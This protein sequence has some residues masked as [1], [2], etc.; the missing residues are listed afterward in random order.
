MPVKKTNAVNLSLF[1]LL[2][3]LEISFSHAVSLNVALIGLAS[4]FLIWRRAFKSLVVL[5]LLP[6]IPAAST[7]WPIRMRITKRKSRF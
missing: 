6:L 7:Y 2:L 1:I 3:T 4:G 5:A